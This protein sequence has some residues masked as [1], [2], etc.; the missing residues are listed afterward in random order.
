MS[1]N[2]HQ[3]KVGDYIIE[4][5]TRQRDILQ[6]FGLNPNNWLIYFENKATIEV[7]NKRSRQRR[8]LN[9]KEDNRCQN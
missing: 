1:S 3:W 4:H 7:V 9:I 8:V 5:D 2:K 6:K